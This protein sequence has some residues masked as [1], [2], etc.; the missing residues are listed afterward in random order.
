[1]LV[2]VPDIGGNGAI[3][4]NDEPRRKV[5]NG[6]L[7]YVRVRIQRDRAIALSDA[8]LYA[9]FRTTVTRC[10]HSCPYAVSNLAGA[11]GAQRLC[12]SRHTAVIG[13]P[14]N[15]HRSGFDAGFPRVRLR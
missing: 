3:V 10:E 9:R 13:M 15:Q 4:Y 14:A 2:D 5:Q 6:Y 1:L 12:H 8:I 7:E 11:I